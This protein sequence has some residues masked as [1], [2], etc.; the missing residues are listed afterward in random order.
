M[1]VTV[2]QLTVTN[3]KLQLVN[4]LFRDVVQLEQLQRGQEFQAGGKKQNSFFNE[5]QNI[6]L[7]LD[8]LHV[9]CIGDS[10]QV[11]SVEAMKE[12]LYE[13]DQLY[14]N[15][16]AVRTKY[17]NNDTLTKK[18]KTLTALLNKPKNN[19]D[20]NIITTE[21]K[22]IITTTIVPAD[23]KRGSS[24]SLWDKV[25]GKKKNAEEPKQLI[26]EELNIT[27][28]TMKVANVDTTL[29]KLSETIATAEISRSNT[30]RD[31][32]N[33]QEQLNQTGNIFIGRLL[34]IL[35]QMEH[36]ETI[37]AQHNNI[38]ATAIVNRNLRRMNILIIAFIVGAAAL[39]FLILADI[40]KS[41][42]YKKELIAARDEAEEAGHVKQRFLANMSHELRTPLQAIVGMA[43]QINIKGEA[44]SRDINMI[45]QSSQH[46]LQIVNEV[47]DYSLITSGKFKMEDKVFN[48]LQLLEEVRNVM[49]VKAAEKKLPLIYDPYI[50]E[51]TNLVGDPFRLKQVLYNLLGNAIKFTERGSVTLSVKQ[52]KF[53]AYTILTFIIKDTGTGISEEDLQK[54][55]NQFEQGGAPA[56]MQQQGTGLGL[57]IVQTLVDRLK[58]TIQ[59]ESEINKGSTFTVSIP[60]TIAKEKV[61]VINDTHYNIPADIGAVWVIDDDPLILELCGLI[62]KKH[63]IKHRCFSIPADMVAAIKTNKPD[64]ILMDIRMPAMTGFE[65]LNKIKPYLPAKTKVYALT[66]HALPDDKEDIL[67]PG[68][69]N[70]L[71]KP[72]M[73]RDLMKILGAAS[74]L[75]EA[76]ELQGIDELRKM[77][78]GDEQ[79]LKQVLLQFT[80]ETRKDNSLFVAAID[81]NDKAAV[82]EHTHKLA[83][84]C[85][86]V[87]FKELA[88]DLRTAEINIRKGRNASAKDLKEL[89]ERVALAINSIEEYLHT[90]A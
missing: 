32:V 53:T 85:G 22:K 9:M 21:S 41:N 26:K 57:S 5:S 68:F 25:F 63:G 52:K 90:T 29:I 24:K 18:L 31:L 61:Q 88:A 6:R 89:Y 66:A 43:E 47:L 35:N 49:E 69:H 50:D 11:A 87:G 64:V 62:L 78:G 37:A 10:Q 67:R 60:Y 84:R 30:R 74:T 86:Q 36:E 16:L 40:I 1:L 8:S 19:I 3:P 80:D 13:R 59:V 56:T 73:E 42:R 38:V 20:S 44:E 23:D 4:R 77:T 82:A 75:T 72:F 76:V 14:L 12:L 2:N 79:L 34:E 39:T 58:G 48:P 55:F 28:D 71:M 54:I 46:L 65:L 7:M 51:A 15:Y 81:S 27:T 45:Y 17:V 33:R 83:G 70:L